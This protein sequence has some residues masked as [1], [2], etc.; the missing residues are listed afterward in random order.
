MGGAVDFGVLSDLT[1]LSRYFQIES[2]KKKKLFLST[3]KVSSNPELA[4]NP[5]SA[6][7]CDQVLTNA[8]DFIPFLCE[9]K[10]CLKVG[11]NNYLTAA[12][13]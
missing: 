2:L 7:D 4:T 12:N 5:E 8:Q 6:A 3:F 13:I 11:F 10:F 9:L 1:D